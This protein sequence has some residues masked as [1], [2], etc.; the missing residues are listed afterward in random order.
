MISVILAEVEYTCAV[1][2]L[3]FCELDCHYNDDIKREDNYIY[4]RFCGSIDPINFRF[5][6]NSFSA[7]V[8]KILI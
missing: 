3:V 8:G 5:R 6:I 2:Y 4:E 1:I 7:I